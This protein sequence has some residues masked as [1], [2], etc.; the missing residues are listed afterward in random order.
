[1]STVPLPTEFQPSPADDLV[2]VAGDRDNDDWECHA[3][4][5]T[6]P[7]LL[8]PFTAPAPNGMV[9][10]EDAVGDTDRVVDGEDPTKDGEDSTLREILQ[11]LARTQDDGAAKADPKL[12][13]RKNACS[14]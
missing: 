6:A 12:V 13:T 8:L 7:N 14:E 11:S 1:M 9:E 4:N 10:G 3:E 2:D 5:V